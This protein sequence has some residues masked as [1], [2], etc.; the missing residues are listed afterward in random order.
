MKH[1]ILSFLTAFAMVFGIVAAPFVNAS[2]AGDETNPENITVNVH[3]ILMNKTDLDAFKEANGDTPKEYKPTEGIESLKEF[4]GNSAEEIDKVYFVAIKEG[5]DGYDDFN[6]KTVE[7]KDAIIN[8]LPETQKGTT[9]KN[10]VGLTLA[11]GTVDNPISYKIY[12]V[13]HK[14]NYK[15]AK[16]ELLSESMAVPTTVTLPNHAQTET[17]VADT[18]N[19]Y[20][21]NTENKPRI[22]KNFDSQAENNAI[23][24]KDLI[25]TNDDLTVD[26]TPEANNKREKPTATKKVGDIVPYRVENIIPVGAEYKKLTWNDNMSE[27]LTYQKDLKIAYNGTALTKGTDYTITET[28][29]GFTLALTNAG[30]GK[31]ET[32][33]KTAEVQIKLTYTAKVNKDA[34]V[35]T[36]QINDISLNYSNKPGND[37][38]PKE[39][40]PGKKEITV[41]KTWDI[42][43]D[44]EITDADEGVTAYFTLQKKVGDEWEDVETQTSTSKEEFTLTFTNLDENETYR[45]VESVKGYEA[46]YQE[47]N[48]ETGQLEI[49]NHKDKENP[50]RIDP[51][52]PKVRLGGRKFVKVNDEEERLEGAEFYVKNSEG[53]YLVI[54]P[55]NTKAVTKAKETLDEKQKAYNDMD[56]EQQK[57]E[58]GKAAKKAFDEAQEAY[59]K[60]VIEN[61][62]EYTWG[63]KDDAITIKSDEE[64]RLEIKGLAYAKGYKLEE[65]TAPEGYAKLTSEVTFN[66]EDGSYASKAGETELQYNKDNT[67]NGYGKKIVNKK[68]TIPQTGGIGSIIFVIAGLMIMGL[69]AYKMKANKEQA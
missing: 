22:D 19:I 13:K 45:V 62:S 68:V 31:I 40:T 42:T 67:D 36:D 59:N 60:A 46:D 49:K 50:D 11:N 69:A 54:A 2:A 3:K 29:R 64:G 32:A 25:G 24:K 39:F 1:K 44:Q 9:T 37:S 27:G 4:F 6:T 61:A 23:T 65:K 51:S 7:E 21:K 34:E 48:S 15:G 5:E 28:D 52:E 63:N 41:K 56:A 26:V 66:V 55:K 12:E 16:G 17:G 20:P 38:E 43:G 35:D 8:A 33:A 47:Y 10:G 58:E 14:S 53:K 57:S 30:L 18:I